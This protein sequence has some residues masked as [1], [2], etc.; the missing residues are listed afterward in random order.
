MQNFKFG[1]YIS[2][3]KQLNVY[4]KF[5]IKISNDRV[6]DTC[7]LLYYNR[8]TG[9]KLVSIHQ[10]Q[11]FVT[12]KELIKHPTNLQIIQVERDHLED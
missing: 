6:R 5:K 1:I 7:L 3:H 8:I 11:L 9:R 4:K 12:N 10:L 2:S